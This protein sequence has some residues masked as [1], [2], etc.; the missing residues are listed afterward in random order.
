MLQDI[1]LSALPGWAIQLAVMVYV[2][3]RE[4]ARLETRMDKHELWIINLMNGEK[5]NDHN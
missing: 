1:D 4:L 2:I 5:H 3:K